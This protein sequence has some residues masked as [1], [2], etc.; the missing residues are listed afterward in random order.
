MFNQRRFDI[1]R[2]KRRLTKKELS[3]KLGLSIQTLSDWETGKVIPK[4]ENIKQLAKVLNFSVSFFE[5]TDL[6]VLSLDDINFRALTKMKA[7][8]RDAAIA[9]GE[10][11]IYL[12]QWIE[13][14]FELPKYKFIETNNDTPENIAKK[15]RE[16]W[17]IDDKCIIDSIH[18]LEKNG[19]RVYSLAEESKDIDAFS[20]IH[21]N[22]PFIFLNNQKTAEHSRFDAMH[23]LGHIIMHSEIKEK[24]R[25]LE[26]EANR[27]AAEMLM[28]EVTVK[29]YKYIKP[30]I[31]NYIRLKVNWKVAL[32]ALIC[33]LAKLE[34]IS[35]W[36]YRILMTEINKRGYNIQEPKTIPKE[37]SFILPK[38]MKIL[39]ED[40]ITI[41]NIANDLDLSSDEVNKLMFGMFPVIYDFKTERIKLRLND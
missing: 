21:E 6:P 8:I 40:G 9:T 11:A 27:F 17:Q 20:V 26:A 12:N 24:S 3:E 15:V 14:R 34:V 36:T 10:L 16:S 1:A 37:K 19:V 35:E 39:N 28:P 32:T 5:G 18:L 31:E 25:E 30:T 33:R 38:L 7:P 41:S 29:E 23:E 13:E 22:Q 2:K 4:Y